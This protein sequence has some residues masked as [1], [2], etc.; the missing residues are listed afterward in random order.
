MRSFNWNSQNIDICFSAFLVKMWSSL[1]KE[2]SE[3]V[4]I[5]S[6]ASNRSEFFHWATN[7]IKMLSKWLSHLCISNIIAYFTHTQ[8]LRQQPCVYTKRTNISNKNHIE[9]VILECVVECQYEW[10]RQ[11]YVLNWCADAITQS[12]NEQWVEISQLWH[13]KLKKST[14][15]IHLY[16]SANK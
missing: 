9:Y 3:M 5:C 1:V 14:N 8:T 4:C 12:H 2:V 7:A 11:L 15:E 16:S 6:I 13:V 10:M